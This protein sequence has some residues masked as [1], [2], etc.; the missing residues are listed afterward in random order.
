[1]IVKVKIDDWT[2]KVLKS[3][4]G[5]KMLG[6]QEMNPIDMIVYSLIKR[7]DGDILDLTEKA[8]KLRKLL[9]KHE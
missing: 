7:E 2:R 4:L 5:F 6:G 9:D 8:G 3:R 1:M